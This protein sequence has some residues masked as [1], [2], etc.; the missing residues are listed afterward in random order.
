MT[1][2]CFK[3]Q[4]KFFIHPLFIIP[5]LH[6]LNFC[7]FFFCVILSLISSLPLSLCWWFFFCFRIFLKTSSF[8]FY[9]S[10]IYCLCKWYLVFIFIWKKVEGNRKQS[11]F[12]QIYVLFFIIGWW[13][14]FLFFLFKKIRIVCWFFY[15][16]KSSFS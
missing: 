15:F 3:M 11:S 14:I 5:Q 2:N 4:V 13:I 7:L 12:D 9:V 6:L 8:F 16:G 10:L 1:I